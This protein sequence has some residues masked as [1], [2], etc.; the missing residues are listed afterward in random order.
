MHEIRC[1]HIIVISPVFAK[2]I[3]KG[4]KIKANNNMETDF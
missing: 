2:V 1:T 4:D 3:C